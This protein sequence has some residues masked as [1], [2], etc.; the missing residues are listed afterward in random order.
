METKNL[1]DYQQRIGAL[2]SIITLCCDF[3]NEIHTAKEIYRVIK[4]LYKAKFSLNT[5]AVAL[6]SKG[7]K[8][9]KIGKKQYFK[10][11]IKYS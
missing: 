3:G 8:S 1:T 5:L 7:F 9:K 10:I 2:Q 4:P 6:K 11:K